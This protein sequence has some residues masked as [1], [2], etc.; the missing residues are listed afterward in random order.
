[1]QSL[2]RVVDQ[3]SLMIYS[4]LVMRVLLSTAQ[5]NQLEN[6]IVAILRMLVSDVML[7]LHVST[8]IVN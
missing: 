1:M 3:F 4:V 6:T 8:L 5:Q 7:M 2:E